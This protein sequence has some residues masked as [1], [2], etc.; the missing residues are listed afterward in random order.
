MTELRSSE[1]E[2]NAHSCVAEGTMVS[3]RTPHFK[4][5]A[6]AALRFFAKVSVFF[7]PPAKLEIETTLKWGDGGGTSGMKGLGPVS[8][9]F[10]PTG[11]QKMC[12]SSMG[13]AQA[14]QIYPA[15]I[16]RATA[17][18]RARDGILSM[19]CILCVCVC[20]DEGEQTL[21]NLWHAVCVPK[22]T[23]LQTQHGCKRGCKRPIC[24]SHSRRIASAVHPHVSLSSKGGTPP[25]IR[26][27]LRP[28]SLQSKR[29]HRLSTP[30][31]YTA[32]HIMSQHEA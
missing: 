21:S 25:R 18:V 24:L 2:K 12:V 30:C 27:Q 4:V 32:K 17:R 31:L 6:C 15:R 22:Q 7:A 5:G 9:F 14:R 16:P 3:P 23:P 8:V 1:C 26:R 19:A 29:L 10:A 11:N 20:V 28:V 13:H